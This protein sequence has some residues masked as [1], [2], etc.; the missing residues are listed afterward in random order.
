MGFEFANRV[1]SDPHVFFYCFPFYLVL[2]NALQFS[3]INVQ[4][5]KRKQTCIINFLLGPICLN[6]DF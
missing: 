4:V 5:L 3:A 2:E 6:F 1:E